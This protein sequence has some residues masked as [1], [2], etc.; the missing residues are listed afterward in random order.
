MISRRTFNK[1]A[2]ALTALVTAKVY[3]RG[4]F[5]FPTDLGKYALL[6]FPAS[7]EDTPMANIW[8]PISKSDTWDSIKKYGVY[9]AASDH[10]WIKT[11]VLEYVPSRRASGGQRQL[12]SASAVVYCEAGAITYVTKDTAAYAIKIPNDLHTLKVKKLYPHRLFSM[13]DQEPYVEV[14]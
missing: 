6:A 2:V 12:Y 7:L 4:D 8:W 5:T 9:D 11:E 10:W 13:K 14:L 1:V 3:A